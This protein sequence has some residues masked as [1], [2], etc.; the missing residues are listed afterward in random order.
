MDE[1][2][3]ESYN[4]KTPFK[5]WNIVRH[6][7]TIYSEDPKFRIAGKDVSIKDT[8]NAA[9]VDC[10]IYDVIEKYRGDL[11]MTAE[12]LNQFHV[13][14]SDEL[15]KIKTLPDAMEAIKAGEQA[16][17]TV[18]ND[19]KK[20]F[21]NNINRFIKEGGAY[22]NKKIKEYDDKIKARDEMTKQFQE[23]YKEQNKSEVTNG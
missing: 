22:F 5:R 17:R 6:T 14:V 11:K 10:N 12:Q 8:Q 20:E 15:S 23:M 18:P 16:W 13:E 19:I 21:G 9:A 7:G 2:R 1:V 3:T 4:K